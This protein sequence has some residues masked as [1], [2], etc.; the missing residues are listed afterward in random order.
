MIPVSPSRPSSLKD[1]F[2]TSRYIAL[3]LCALWQCQHAAAQSPNDVFGNTYTVAQNAAMAASGDASAAIR[4]GYAYLTGSAGVIDANQAATYFA[5]AGPNSRPATAWLGYTYAT[6]PAFATKQSAGVSMVT[7]A[8]NAG[9]PVGMTLLGRLYSTGAGVP[10]DV[11]TAM[12]WYNK[13]GSQFALAQTYLAE[14]YLVDPGKVPA[15]VTLL[16]NAATQ[17]EPL[18]INH[19]A[20][21]YIRGQGVGKDIQQAGNWIQRGVQASS[22][23]A[24]YFR[25]LQYARGFGVPRSPQTAFSYFVRSAAVG[26]IPAEAAV[27]VCYAS[28]FGVQKNL[29]LAKQWLSQ[30]ASQD[31]YAAKELAGL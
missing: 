8:A 30:V 13:A 15:A 4:A 29:T 22:Y 14:L 17:G 19:L 25:G 16:Q 26:Y 18:S 28:G 11:N 7:G 5:Q 20:V 12:S 1:V 31:S 23:V 2:M 9:D 21:M 27:G 24:Y 6:S 3:S 10:K